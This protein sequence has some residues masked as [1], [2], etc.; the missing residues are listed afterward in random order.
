M[1][2]GVSAAV[3]TVRIR[4]AKRGKVRFISHRDV[5]RAFERALRVS[6]VPVASTQGF[7]PHPRIAFGLAL[8]VG[9]ES[10]AEYL[11]VDLDAPMAADEVVDR[12][13]AALP[14]GLTPDGAVEL[15]TGAPA[16]QEAVTSVEYVMEIP[17]RS[18]AVDAAVAALLAAEVVEATRSRKG[19]EATDDVRPLVLGLSAAAAGAGRTRLHAETATRPR[20]LRPSE[21]LDVLV[22]FLGSE[23]GAR[24][25]EGRVRR[26]R[27]WIERGGARL[28]P[29]EADPRP[30]AP[31]VRA[32]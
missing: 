20:G 10:D 29:L 32:S 26:I 3:G 14:D 31:E 12:L 27:Q 19:R 21:L 6:G 22:G 18:A 30:L 28:E 24:P 8:A 13:G 7:T 17:A 15:A 23:A 11:D 5:A 2:A 16:L 4:F 9:H 1:S 25:T